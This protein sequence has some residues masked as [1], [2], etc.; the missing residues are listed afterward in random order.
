MR[1]SVASS[2]ASLS[3]PRFSD[4]NKMM[5]RIG[6]DYMAFVYVCHHSRFVGAQLQNMLDDV[7]DSAVLLR[8][9]PGV[10]RLQ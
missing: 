7:Q 1:G 9:G 6:D 2:S 5:E 10:S 8:V 3:S 4:G